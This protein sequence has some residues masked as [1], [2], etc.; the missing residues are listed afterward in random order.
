MKTQLPPL[1][2]AWN[3]FL[4]YWKRLFRIVQS[5][6][7]AW[8]A[9]HKPECTGSTDTNASTRPLCMKTPSSP[10]PAAKHPKYENRYSLGAG[11]EAPLCMPASGSLNLSKQ[12]F[13]HRCYGRYPGWTPSWVR[14]GA[15][16]HDGHPSGVITTAVTTALPDLW[17]RH[18]TAVSSYRRTRFTTVDTGVWEG[19]KNMFRGFLLRFIHFQN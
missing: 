6:Q 5:L 16:L 10:C 14:T 13:P 19:N 4:T 7:A 15:V 9:V 3:I 1:Y 12:H 2:L 17:A 11:R 8:V 18:I